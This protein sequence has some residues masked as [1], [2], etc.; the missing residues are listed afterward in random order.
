MADVTARLIKPLP[1]RVLLKGEWWRFE[2]EADMKGRHAALYARCETDG[3]TVVIV[4]DRRGNIE[5]PL[6]YGL[7]V[8]SGTPLRGMMTALRKL[9]YVALESRSKHT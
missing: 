8:K 3:R 5:G 4:E 2:R 7:H 9:G 1:R 6:H